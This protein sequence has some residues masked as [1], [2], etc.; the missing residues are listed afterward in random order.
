M[1]GTVLVAT[2][3][4][5][6]FVV[7]GENRDQ[8]L[9]GQM[10]NALASDGH[11]GAFAIVSGHSLRRRTRDGEWLMLAM[12]EFQLACC[13]PV[14]DAIYVGTDDARV[15]RVSANGTSK[16]SATSGPLSVETPGMRARPSSMVSASDH[17]LGFVR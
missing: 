2:W 3:G 13:A 9:A 17:H 15:L 16:T 5:G 4:D 6:L 8:E 14:A 11:G 10:V 1:T 7:T 12:S